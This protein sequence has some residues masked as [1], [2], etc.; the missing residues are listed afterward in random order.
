M[1]HHKVKNA[2]DKT[3]SFFVG[4]PAASCAMGPATSTRI[5][6][7]TAVELRLA[8]EDLLAIFLRFAVVHILIYFVVSRMRTAIPDVYVYDV[9]SARIHEQTLTLLTISCQMY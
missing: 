2:Q 6:A 7:F 8:D 5:V 1:L 4:T 3:K 9:P